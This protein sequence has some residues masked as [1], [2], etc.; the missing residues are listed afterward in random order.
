MAKYSYEFRELA[1]YPH[2]IMQGEETIGA[3]SSQDQAK[4]II[5][6][7]NAYTPPVEPVPCTWWSLPLPTEGRYIHRSFALTLNQPREAFVECVFAAETW[8]V[9]DK[10]TKWLRSFTDDD[11]FWGPIP[12]A[13]GT[14]DDGSGKRVEESNG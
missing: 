11:M 9:T 6:A 14:C 12:F 10:R 8:W 13:P 1:V 7:L 5:D 3:V 4:L 2:R